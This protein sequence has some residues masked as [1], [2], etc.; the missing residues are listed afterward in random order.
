AAAVIAAELANADAVVFSDYA[1]GFLSPGLLQ[2]SIAVARGA[3][4]PIFVDPKG[5]DWR[6]YLGASLL[7][8]NRAELSIL[9][10]L[11]VRDHAQTLQA[12]ARLSA[13]LPGCD[14]IV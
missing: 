6:R 2:R 10:G 4:V 3:G 5:A 14:I 7:K 13:A 1:K 8:P 11:P 9:T 12:G